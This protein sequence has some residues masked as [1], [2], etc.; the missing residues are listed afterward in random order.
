MLATGDAAL[1]GAHSPCPACLPSPHPF[2]QAAAAEE[3]SGSGGDILSKCSITMT[4]NPKYFPEE[5]YARQ[6]RC[7]WVL[8]PAGGLAALWAGRGEGTELCQAGRRR[9]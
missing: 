2:P 9:T 1:F 6:K 8:R 3:A 7:G 5:L 4:L